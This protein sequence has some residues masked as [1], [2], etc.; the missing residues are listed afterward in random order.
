MKKTITAI[1]TIFAT[2][3]VVVGACGVAATHA[4]T[5]VFTDACLDGHPATVITVSPCGPTTPSASFICS[6][7]YAHMILSTDYCPAPKVV[8][9]GESELGT[10]FVPYLFAPTRL[11]V[12]MRRTSVQSMR[13][14]CAHMGGA[15]LKLQHGSYV[16]HGVDY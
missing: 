11:D 8:I 1:A 16:C 10:R 14:R 6:H 4:D 3:L 2:I 13:F 12:A 9:V 5:S 7:G 15:N